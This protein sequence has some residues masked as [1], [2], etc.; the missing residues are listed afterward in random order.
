MSTRISKCRNDFC[1][2]RLACTPSGQ[3]H[4][5][6]VG[7]PPAERSGAV[8]PE[9]MGKTPA[10]VGLDQGARPQVAADGDHVLAVVHLA[11]VEHP[12]GRQGLDRL[13]HHRCTGAYG[14]TQAMWG[15]M[16]SA[17]SWP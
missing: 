17:D 6:R 10:A 8:L 11:E 3:Q 4:A 14:A 5:A 1:S 15:S 2:D 9:P 12:A 13:G 7:R 16:A